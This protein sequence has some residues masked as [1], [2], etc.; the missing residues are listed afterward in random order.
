[1]SSSN[2]RTLLAV[3]DEPQNIAVVGAMLKPAYT[4]QV[5]TDG[6]KAL[7]LAGSAQQPDLILLDIM[8]PRM[9]GYETLRRLKAD[10]R[11]RAIPVVFMSA[12]GDIDD[13]VK[14][15]KE[16]VSDYVTKPL[17]PAF[18]LSVVRRLLGQGSMRPSGRGA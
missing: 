18:V 13:K 4:V 12:K 8:M 7:E 15:Y 6:R 16:G 3:D 2:R 17:D 5:A 1:M 9:N 14:G 11:T 10:A